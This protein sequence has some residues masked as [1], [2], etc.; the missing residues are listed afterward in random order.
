MDPMFKIGML[1]PEEIFINKV[2][3]YLNIEDIESRDHYASAFRRVVCIV[4]KEKIKKISFAEIGRLL[5]VTDQIGNTSKR[6][7][8]LYKGENKFY[9]FIYLNVSNIYDEK[10]HF[11]LD[12]FFRRAAEKFPESEDL[13]FFKAKPIAIFL[14]KQGVS[15]S[16]INHMLGFPKRTNAMD[17]ELEKKDLYLSVIESTLDEMIESLKKCKKNSDEKRRIDN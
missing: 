17:F 7:M 3:K 9:H 13:N 16:E 11:S 1:S 5:F 8:P 15:N 2:A 14:V 12:E 6:A 10:C 4:M